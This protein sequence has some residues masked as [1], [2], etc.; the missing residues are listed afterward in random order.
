M[1]NC[2]KSKGMVGNVIPAV[3]KSGSKLFDCQN[4]I[5]NKFDRILDKSFASIKIMLPLFNKPHKGSTIMLNTIMLNEIRIEGNNFFLPEET[6]FDNSID[7]TKILPVSEAILDDLM[8]WIKDGRYGFDCDGKHWIHNTQENW[9]KHLGYS[10][11]Q[12]KRGIKQCQDWGLIE[13]RCFSKN[14][15]N[16]ELSYTIIDEEKYEKTKQ[17]LKRLRRLG[18]IHQRS[19]KSKPYKTAQKAHSKEPKNASITTA[20]D[21]AN[22]PSNEPMYIYQK[23]IHKSYKSGDNISGDNVPG[24]TVSRGIASKKI[25][26]GK[27]SS[28]KIS[29]PKAQAKSLQEH[30]EETVREVITE[31]IPK[32]K[33]HIIQ[34]MI[35]SLTNIFPGLMKA[36]RLTK[37]ICRNLV[38]A[39]QR[40]FH[41][42]I[43]E[44]ERYLKLIATSS[45]L[46]GE[47]FKLSIYWILKFLTIDRILN[48]EF[49][50]NPD[51]ITYTEKEQEKMEEKRKQK[52]QQKIADI[53]ETETCKQAR[54]KVLDILGIGDYQQ[55]FGNP[56]KCRFTERNGEILI[57]ILGSEPWNFIYKSQKL[58]QIDIRIK[59]EWISEFIEIKQ[60]NG[61]KGVYIA[62]SF[63][64]LER[65]NASQ[66]QQKPQSE[67]QNNEETPNK[68]LWKRIFK[69][70]E[71]ENTVS[72]TQMGYISNIP[73]N[74]GFNFAY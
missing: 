31:Q 38:A 53:N 45:Y 7:V 33:P 24:N 5:N 35:K 40:K 11:S 58:E 67:Q 14:K 64:E 61:Y 72:E 1:T 17:E 60:E 50:V 65:I 70:K 59:I 43:E 28:E 73:E 20:N 42:S 69:A 39:F 29:A 23:K 74:F 30:N 10:R 27:V 48:G 22:E 54:V 12:F 62:K 6:L 55:Y 66:Q 44:W 16:R 71:P 51:K 56:N 52:I 21:T 25:S 34:D 26:S 8:Y 46:N 15:R 2:L 9:A 36:F 13:A 18:V 37:A 68:P 47:K 32:E 4:Q 19:E 49:G 63:E 41:N 57:E 3:R